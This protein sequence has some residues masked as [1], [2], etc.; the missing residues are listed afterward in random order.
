MDDYTAATLATATRDALRMT[1][2]DNVLAW[3]EAEDDSQL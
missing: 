1:H 2:L 3:L